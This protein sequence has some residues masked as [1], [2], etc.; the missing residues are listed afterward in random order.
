MKKYSEFLGDYLSKHYGNLFDKQKGKKQK[1]WD[2]YA[3]WEN[4]VMY[5]FDLAKISD[6]N[7]YISRLGHPNH[8]VIISF[9][10]LSD[11]DCQ[12]I[13]YLKNSNLVNMSGTL[14]IKES[15][16]EWNINTQDLEKVHHQNL[17]SS[18]LVINIENGISNIT[19]N[20]NNCKKVTQGI[21]IIVYDKYVD[22]LVDTV[23]FDSKNGFVAVR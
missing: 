10:N 22:I 1:S 4:Q 8:Y 17:G 9:D 16:K 15:K 14:I 12:K 20:R 6:V 13:S 2:L 3:K 21:N 18:D 11:E 7:E 23:G 19:V 5:D